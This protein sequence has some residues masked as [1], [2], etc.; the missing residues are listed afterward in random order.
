MFG[1]FN[2]RR[3]V[4]TIAAVEAIR[5]LIASI[6]H[7]QGLSPG[8]WTT[9][10]ILGFLTFTAGHHAKLATRGSIKTEEL[11]A[12]MGDILTSVSNLNGRA[13]VARTVEM[14]SNDDV[15]FNR[16]ADDAAAICFYT[17]RILKN[18]AEHPLVTMASKVA[19][20]STDAGNTE[21]E[22][23]AY[24]ASMMMMLSLMSEVHGIT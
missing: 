3:K 4:A 18:E 16:G 15:D 10:Y 5:P 22:R 1:L 11:G 24:I 7:S 13:L 2:S 12:A 8:F 23:R 19:Q 20:R 6:Q 17:M 14:S 21:P 9:P